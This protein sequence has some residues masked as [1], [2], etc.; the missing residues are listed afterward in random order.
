MHLNTCNKVKKTLNSVCVTHNNSRLRH[1]RSM[2]CFWSLSSDL[3][4]LDRGR[5]LTTVIITRCVLDRHW[6]LVG[7]QAVPL[8]KHTATCFRPITTD[9]TVAPL[10]SGVCCGDG[11]CRLFIFSSNTFDARSTS[12]VACT[13]WGTPR[14]AVIVAQ[15]RS[16][17]RKRAL[18]PVVR[19]VFFFWNG[20][21]EAECG[22]S[23]KTKLLTTSSAR[24]KP[25]SVDS[26]SHHCDCHPMLGRWES[27]TNDPRCLVIAERN[28]HSLY[29]RALVSLAALCER[30]CAIF[31]A[32]TVR[33]MGSGQSSSSTPTFGSAR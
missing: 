5:R 17:S 9:R 1:L 22:T 18:Q 26:S 20:V 30:V 31:S 27:R 8:V 25:K 6:A 15:D 12:H 16:W 2:A 29:C 33:L 24:T 23:E 19:H 3:S 11:V 4:L 13:C 14:D 32:V 28:S 21:E 10:D 7:P